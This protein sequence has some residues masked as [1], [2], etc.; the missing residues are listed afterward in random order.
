MGISYFLINHTRMRIA[1]ADP[2]GIGKTLKD[3]NWGLD[4]NI[5]FLDE[6]NANIANLIDR[7]G[8]IIDYKFW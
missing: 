7:D 5:D 4:D 8:Y 3:L 6:F 1:S 2:Y